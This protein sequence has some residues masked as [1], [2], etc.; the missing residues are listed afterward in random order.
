MPN[1]FSLIKKSTLL[2]SLT[3]KEISTY[4]SDGSFKKTDYH[5]N[6]ILHFAGDVCEKLELILT[7]HVVVERIDESGHLMTLAE[8]F[9]DD[10]IGGNLFSKNPRYPLTITAKQSSVI[11]EIKKERLFEL[12]LSHPPL[13]NKYLEFISD[14]A[15]ILG[16]RI[17]RYVNR[18]IRESVV[19]FL[20]YERK[21]QNTNRIK[22]RMTKK[23]L[24]ERIGVQRTS[25]SRELAKMKKDG[26]IDYDKDSITILS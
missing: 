9:G 23:A 20:E 8:F 26:L 5:K 3:D 16:D 6:A 19:S 13:L 25:L 15:T 21:R 1:L 7:G 11:L 18:T 4:L 2:N 12:F 17:N 24:A 10:L 22:L 14:H